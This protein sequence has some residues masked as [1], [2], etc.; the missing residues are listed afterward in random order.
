MPIRRGI[1]TERC[2]PRGSTA[3]YKLGRADGHACPC[4]VSGLAR[5]DF[6]VAPGVTRPSF[7]AMTSL[8]LGKRQ[9][10]G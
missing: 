6:C 8:L 5:N 4:D 1:R 10:V 2:L 7:P 9:S 3:G